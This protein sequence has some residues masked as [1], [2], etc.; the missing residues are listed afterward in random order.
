MK[1]KEILFIDDGNISA[2]IEKLKGILKKNGITITE[3]FLNLKE[4][5][6]RIAD[7]TNPDETILDFDKL[8]DDI[9]SQYIDKK[10]D[11]VLCDFNFNDKNV[12]GF[13]LIKWLKNVSKSHSKKI[14]FAKF[15]LY[16]SERDKYIKDAF[17]EDEIG[18]LIKLKLEDFYERTRVS[19]QLAQAILNNEQVIDLKKKLLEA[20]DRNRDLTFRSVY[21]KFSGY[22]LGR[23]SS[24][25]EEET[26]HG[27]LFQEVLLELAVAHF[28][29]LNDVQ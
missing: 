3:S 8:K 2:I 4:P 14:R 9:S 22:S 27:I 25:I 13:K 15:S 12:N 10:Y 17:T 18:N 1:T 5:K 19:E 7:P 29:E 24:E 21:P 26:H 20:L 6:Y 28:I 11:Y 23:I 16:S